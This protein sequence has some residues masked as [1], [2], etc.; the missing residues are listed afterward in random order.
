MIS[1]AFYIASFQN[2]FIFKTFFNILFT[3]YMVAPYQHSTPV[4]TNLGFTS[5][6]QPK[7]GSTGCF[8][9]SVPYLWT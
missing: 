1:E 2:H 4:S 9:T 3:D 5:N 6:S 7:A 8:A